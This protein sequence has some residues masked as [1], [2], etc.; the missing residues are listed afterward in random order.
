MVMSRLLVQSIAFVLFL[1]F[2]QGATAQGQPASTPASTSSDQL[3]KPE[4]LDALVSPIAL[5]PDT[6]LAEVLMASTYPLEVVQGAR[7]IAENKNL[8]GDALKAEVDKQGWD[9]SIKS[10]TATPDVLKMMSDKLD[11]TQKLGDAVLAQQTDVMDSVQ[12]LRA[13]ADAN[14]KLKTTKQ[15][16]VTK[17]S[18][19]GKQYI[20]I[21]PTD[22]QTVYVP[23]YDPAVVYGAWPY[24]AYPPYYWGASY[25][26]G[27]G[28]LL[29]T[30]LAFGAGYAVGRW[31][32]GGNYWGGGVNWGNN[33][34]NV[35]RPV[36]INNSG[37]NWNHNADH[38][39][40][41]R[42]NNKDVANK[43]N[44]GNNIRGGAQ[45]RMDFRG[46]DGKQALRPGGDGR[47]GGGDRPGA[48]GDRRPG[49]GDR[50]GNR[51]GGGD[52]PGAKGGG[53]RRDAGNRG[54]D[55]PGGGGK[56]Q[57]RPG[58]G[59]GK[60]ASRPSGGAR[61]GGGGGGGRSAFAGSG[62]GRG[63][64]AQA[65][66]GHASLGGRGGGGMRMGGGGGG[67]FR[68]GGGGGRG[69][70]GGGRGGGGRRSDIALK[71]D[72]NL[73]GYLGNGL[74]FYRF[75]YN[76]SD[77]AY[78]GVMAQEVQTLRPDAVVRG[79]DGYLR[80][81]YDKLGL[82]FMTYKQWIASGSRI[83][84]TASGSH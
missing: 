36:N 72:I 44:K 51:P 38:R 52:R 16:T 83:P 34:I 46:H 62:A 49:G 60:A 53:E 47:P 31:A 81:F 59:Q 21:E 15:Q 84:S 32:S 75:S 50:A 26:P 12:R 41:V 71:H 56:G 43:F 40:G 55:R 61:P 9:E 4:Q 58:G 64:M 35:N 68:G 65:S 74:G 37:N 66:R 23:Y 70:G 27:G 20:A 25:W 19:G 77:K 69:G 1:A 73:L 18:E 24:P 10:L 63:A 14:D 6:L 17:K 8:K 54:G 78:V 3:L 7:W 11:W 57:A 45:N 79:S 22:P 67:G 82:E 13:K 5:Y 28:A 42:Y 33:N 2:A 30:G 80:V 39:H 76:G 29:A 48:G